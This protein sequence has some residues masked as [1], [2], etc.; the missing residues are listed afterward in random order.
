MVKN[1]VGYN[2]KN[3]PTCNYTYSITCNTINANVAG[4][5]I[6][7][8]DTCICKGISI[9]GKKYEYENGYGSINTCINAPV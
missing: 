5:N 9:K 4:Y 6:R 8:T 3:I 2:F 1:D 7:I